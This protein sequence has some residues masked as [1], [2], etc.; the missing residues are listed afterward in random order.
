VG[1]SL[2]A[3]P[4]LVN[5]SAV[6]S[7][8]VQVNSADDNCRPSRRQLE[9][10]GSV[11]R[12][13]SC[14]CDLSLTSP[15]PLAFP[16]FAPSLS[17]ALCSSAPSCPPLPLESSPSCPDTCACCLP[18]S[19]PPLTPCCLP[20]PAPPYPLLP[21]LLPCGSQLVNGRP[22]LPSRAR[23]CTSLPHECASSTRYSPAGK[24][25]SEK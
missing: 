19:W 8:T 9:V 1:D 22:R 12:A 6:S 5:G 17:L 13:P 24:P 10:E 14:T 23:L 2:G 25:T 16:T 3:P 11:Q 4:S 21:P 20:P 7:A 18:P 15:L